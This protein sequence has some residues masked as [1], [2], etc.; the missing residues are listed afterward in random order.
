MATYVGF[1]GAKE[2][3]NERVDVAESEHLAFNHNAVEVVVL[4]DGDLLDA[5]DSKVSVIAFELGQNYL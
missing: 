5:F 2:F 4:D 1:E 3:A